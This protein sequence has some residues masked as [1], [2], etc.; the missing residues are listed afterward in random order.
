MSTKSTIRQVRINEWDIRLSIQKAS[1][2]SVSDWC[3]RNIF[4]IHQYFFWKHQIKLQAIKQMLLDIIH[5]SLYQSPMNLSSS[6][7]LT[8]LQPLKII[9][10][11]LY[12][13]QIVHTKG[14]INNISIEHDSSASKE[15]IRNVEFFAA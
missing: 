5:M 2:L 11:P 9:S 14:L 10:Q 7:Q 12:V 3:E 8:F 15:F 1:S 4:S 13:I 6:N